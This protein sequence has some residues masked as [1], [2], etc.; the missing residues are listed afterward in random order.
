[1]S[2]VDN[3]DDNRNDEENVATEEVEDD[4]GKIFVGA[5]SWDTTSARLVFTLI[6]QH[7]YYINQLNSFLSL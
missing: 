2:D 5:L 6:L 3:N 7:H 4:A 1:M